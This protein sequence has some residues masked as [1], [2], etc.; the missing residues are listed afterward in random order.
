MTECVKPTREQV[1]EWRRDGLTWREI[2]TMCGVAQSTVLRYAVTLDLPA[3]LFEIRR[4][5]VT[6]AQIRA[7]VIDKQ[8]SD[9]ALAT[10]LG[11]SVHSA[12]RRRL[13]A[14]VRRDE[15]G[16]AVLV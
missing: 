14:G 12:Q 10:H 7:L 2:G 15:N 1:I 13:R 8:Y 4:S 5:G 16:K 9:R 11:L 6:V 3:E